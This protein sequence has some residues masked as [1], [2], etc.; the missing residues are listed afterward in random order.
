[1]ARKTLYEGKYLR[2]LSENTWEFVKRR[3]C[4]GI[5]IVAAMTRGR[6]LIFV[7]QFRQPVN[8][9]VIEWPAGLAN[10]IAVESEET[11]ESGALRELF[12][13]TGYEASKIRHLVT[14][15]V[16]AGLSMDYV[17]FFLATGLKK[18]GPGGGDE[19]ESITVHEVP[20]DRAEKWIRAKQKKGSRVDPKVFVGIYFIEKLLQKR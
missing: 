17:S 15:P 16:N 13:E 1:M 8:A 14:G 7:E 11:L 19:T 9:N 4:T 3:N 10:D 18:K 20:L 6:K 12:E 5:V 2:L